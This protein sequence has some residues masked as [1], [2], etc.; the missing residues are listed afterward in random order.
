MGTVDTQDLI[1]LLNSRNDDV[2]AVG[3]Y[4]RARKLCGLGAQWGIE[5]FVR[6]EMGFEILMCEIGNGLELESSTQRP[7]GKNQS[8]ERLSQAEVLRGVSSRYT[9]ITAQRL[10]LDYSAMV[11]AFWYDLNLTNPDIDRADLPRLPASNRE[12]LARIQTDLKTAIDDSWTRGG[13]GNDWQGIV[14]MIITRYSDRLQLMAEI[15]TS[16]DTILTHIAV[17]LNLYIDYRYFD[18]STARRK[19][20]T[21]YLTVVPQTTAD[22]MIY[23]AVLTVMAR[24]CNTLFHIRERLLSEDGMTHSSALDESK[25]L[26][27]VL[28]EYL[29]WTTWRE[30]GKC[31]HDEVCFVAIWPW[32]SPEDHEHPSCIKEELLSIRHGYWKGSPSE[33]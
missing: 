15:D 5:G 26:L 17:L 2:S 8:H 7:S 20:S 21:H 10:I 29:G 16:G 3:D 24:I 12:G 19:C 22:Y 32:G 4:N 6:M 30:C 27:K 9:G 13:I 18:L 33:Y 11:S 1:L 14:D 28:I 23:E 25:S 31:S